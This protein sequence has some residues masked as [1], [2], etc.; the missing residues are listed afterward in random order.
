[1]PSTVP[2]EEIVQMLEDYGNRLMKDEA[3]LYHRRKCFVFF[4]KQ[5][6]HCFAQMTLNVT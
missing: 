2:S 6:Q 4:F 3:A 5:M 1:V